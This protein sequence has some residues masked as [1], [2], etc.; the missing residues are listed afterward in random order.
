MLPKVSTFFHFRKDPFL[1]GRET[2][3]VELLR[4]YLP[5]TVYCLDILSG[6]INVKNIWLPL[7]KGSALKRKHLLPL[8]GCGGGGICSLAEGDWCARMYS[9][10]H[11]R[12]CLCIF[13]NGRISELAER[14]TRCILFYF[15]PFG[16][17]DQSRYLS[18]TYANS[19][20]PDE[21]ACDKPSHQ[22]LHCFLLCC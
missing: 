2:I 14:I 19:I 18:N 10:P 6:V 4:S 16:P 7:K 5:F 17:G 21:A 12:F 13:K 9:G 8:W 20:D 11:K 22:D 3:V 1:E 15:N